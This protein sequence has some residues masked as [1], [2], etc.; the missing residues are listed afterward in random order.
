MKT[1]TASRFPRIALP[2]AL[3]LAAVSLS[4]AGLVTESAISFSKAD[5]DTAKSAQKPLLIFRPDGE[6]TKVWSVQ[7]AGMDPNIGDARL[8]IGDNRKPNSEILWRIEVPDGIGIKEFQWA[9]ANVALT[10]S[11]GAEVYF[12]WEYSVNGEDW[13]ELFSIQNTEP[14]SPEVINLKKRQFSGEFA[15]PYPQS[16]FIRASNTG[17][18]ASGESSYYAIWSNDPDGGESP[19]SFVSLTVDSK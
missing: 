14:N 16:F 17:E 13:E 7:N 18:I 12:R 9:I 19:D 11:K 15:S 10:G 3:L 6:P 1:Q 2:C 8:K 4:R 5:F